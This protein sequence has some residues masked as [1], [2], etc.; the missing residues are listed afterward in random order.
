[1]SL[2]LPGRGYN[3]F[4]LLDLLPNYGLEYFSEMNLSAAI[5]LSLCEVQKCSLQPHGGLFQNSK[6]TFRC[7]VVPKFV[8]LFPMGFKKKCI[9]LHV[10]ALRSDLPKKGI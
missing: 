4:Q 8:H 6:R 10:F 1:V 7:C 5:C 3:L 9:S 2:D